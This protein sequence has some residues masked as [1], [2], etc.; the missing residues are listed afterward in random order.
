M[1]TI[2]KLHYQMYESRVTGTPCTK[3]KTLILHR[4]LHPNPLSLKKFVSD[5]I[6]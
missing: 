5:L 1:G 2:P 6:Q 3:W 4:D